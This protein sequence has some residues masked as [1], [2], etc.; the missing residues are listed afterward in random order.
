MKTGTVI[1]HAGVPA[2]KHFAWHVVD[3][4]MAIDLPDGSVQM[5]P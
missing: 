4:R 5:Q 1:V 2:K 3:Q